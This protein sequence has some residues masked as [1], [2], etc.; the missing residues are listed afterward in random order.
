MSY[1]EP[2]AIAREKTAAIP[3]VHEIQQTSSE[4]YKLGMGI[5]GAFA[6][7]I[8]IWGIICLSSAVISTGGPIALI[9]SMF[10]ALS[11]SM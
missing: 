3:T 2:K 9:K 10:G 5:T 6:V 11:G 1:M 7:I 4:L 8:G